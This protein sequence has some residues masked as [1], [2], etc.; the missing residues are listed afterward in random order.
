[1]KSSFIGE[2]EEASEVPCQPLPRSGGAGR[3]CEH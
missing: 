3:S 1:V 2:R